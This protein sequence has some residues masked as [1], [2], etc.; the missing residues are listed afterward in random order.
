MEAAASATTRAEPIE[1]AM[2][3]MAAGASA[4]AAAAAATTRAEPMK[5]ATA[6][7]AAGESA[8]AGDPMEA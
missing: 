8:A 2:A 3:T 7:V 4:T 5:A 6:T 1:A